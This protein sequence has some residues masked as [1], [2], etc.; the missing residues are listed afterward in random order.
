MTTITWVCLPFEALSLMQLY[1]IMA[2]RQ[3]VFI[4]EQNCPYL[5]ADGK[6]PHAHHLLG[7]DTTGFLVAYARLLPK[8]ISYSEGASIGRVVNSPK[9]RGLGVGRLLMQ[10]SINRVN[11][12]FGDTPIYISAQL[13]LKAFYESFGFVTIS[14]PY[15]EDD[16][17]HIKMT[18]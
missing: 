15:L 9:V 17:L 14:E 16:I 13:Y 1:D 10:E 5:D 7:I 4:I 2:L 18:L 11:E 8:G 12:L 3:E 6:D